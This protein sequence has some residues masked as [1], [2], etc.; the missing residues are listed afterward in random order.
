MEKSRKYIILIPAALNSKGVLS[1]R[2]D[3]RAI[4][5]RV[6]LQLYSEGGECS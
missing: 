6:E 3:M 2:G 1:P 5:D 4:L